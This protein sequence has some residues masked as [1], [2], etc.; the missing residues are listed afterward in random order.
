MQTPPLLLHLSLPPTSGHPTSRTKPTF[1]SAADSTQSRTY[2]LSHWLH[3]LVPSWPLAAPLCLI[4]STSATLPK[5]GM[6]FKSFRRE[7]VALWE[8]SRQ[9]VHL[10]LTV[11]C[12]FS[13][14]TQSCLTL[15]DP[16]D[17]SMP[18]LPVHHQLPELAQTPVQWIRDAIQPSHSLS[19]PSPPAFSLP[20]IRVFSNES[21]L[22][23]RWPKYWSFSFSINPSNEY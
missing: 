12:Q 2:F 3:D 1:P 6:N 17:C 18:G 19:H 16:M 5:N 10:F 20:S 23:N 14:V 15:C 22:R 4:P 8:K 21:V 9:I 13:S 11:S 7:W